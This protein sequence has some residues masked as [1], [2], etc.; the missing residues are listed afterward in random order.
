MLYIYG[1]VRVPDTSTL[2]KRYDNVASTGKVAV[3]YFSFAAV[4]V[5]ERCRRWVSLRW[6]HI[7]GGDSYVSVALEAGQ[8]L[9]QNIR[10]RK[11]IVSRYS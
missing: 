2:L 1:M 8:Q 7:S 4:K 9:E 5:A 11:I 10:R 6:I 3:L